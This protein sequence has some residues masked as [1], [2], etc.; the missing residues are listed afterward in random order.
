MLCNLILFGKSE[1]ELK[2]AWLPDGAIALL[3]G[4]GSNCGR[5][6]YPS[7]T[8]KELGVNS[9]LEGS[10]G[11]GAGVRP[12][13]LKALLLAIYDC[14]FRQRTQGGKADWQAVW[15]EFLG[16]RGV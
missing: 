1:D 6:E 2:K 11:F 10:A 9:V 7:R 14:R 4:A 3:F 15:V 12:Q 16:R 8:R 13:A 5:Q